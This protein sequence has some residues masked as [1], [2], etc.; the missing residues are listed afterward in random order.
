MAPELVL[1]PHVREKNAFTLD[2]YLQHGGYEPLKKALAQT[3]DQII[4]RLRARREV[5]GEHDVTC[6]FRY[7]GLPYEDAEASMRTYARAVLP[8]L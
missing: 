5:V 3:P 2:F 6:C 1:I 7:A 8:A 4:E